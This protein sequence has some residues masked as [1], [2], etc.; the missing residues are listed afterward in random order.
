MAVC[1]SIES[2]AIQTEGAGERLT[3]AE[4]VTLRLDTV[5]RKNSRDP[6]VQKSMTRSAALAWPRS[7][8]RHR[9]SQNRFGFANLA[10]RSQAI[11]PI[12]RIE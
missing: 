6:N 5:H 10:L 4:N 8:R 2:G 12:A 1:I 9:N 7:V 11:N 3:S